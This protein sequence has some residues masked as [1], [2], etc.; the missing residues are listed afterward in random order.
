MLPKFCK[1]P[2]FREPQER[3]WRVENGKI[4]RMPKTASKLHLGA[5]LFDSAL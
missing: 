2:R 1:I 5:A 3:R 4:W